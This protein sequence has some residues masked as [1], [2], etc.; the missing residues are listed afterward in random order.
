VSAVRILDWKPRQSGLL[1]GFVTVE[2][3]SGLIFH[4][5]A[6]FEKL[7]LWW[8]SPPGKPRVGRD[9]LA[10][11]E[12]NGKM[13]YDDVVTFADKSRRDIWSNTVI[14]ALQVARPEIFA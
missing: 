14:S 2:F 5:C 3:P 7:G 9:G 8:A 12:P 6:V 4:E 11:K 10:V 13:K 1:Q